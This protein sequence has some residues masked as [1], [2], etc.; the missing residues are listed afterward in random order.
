MLRTGLI[1]GLSIGLVASFIACG[2]D[3]FTEH[4]SGGSAPSGGAGGTGG[5]TGGTL[6]TGGSNTGGS[7]GG[8]GGSGGGTGGTTQS[9]FDV[10]QDGVTDC[11]GDCDD[12]DPSSFP[13]APEICGD[14]LDNDCDGDPDQ[15]AACPA[16]LG[17]YVSQVTG[18]DSNP[19]TQASP[20]QTIAQ[21][22]A[23]ALTL[24]NGQDVFV[25]EG[26]YVEKVTLVDAVSLLGGYHCDANT[27]DWARDPS[28]YV[29]LIQN[30][31]RQ[32]VL[33]DVTVSNITEISGFTIAGI[34]SSGLGGY[35]TPGTA[36]VTLAGG[37]AVVRSNIINAGDEVNCNT[38]NECSSYGVR[39]V[40]PTNDP[41]SGVLI[42]NN[43][44]TAGSSQ[45][46]GCPAVALV[47]NPAPI[48]KLV[49]NWIKGGTCNYNRAVD[50]WQSGAGTLIQNNDIFAG[51]S[52]TDTSFAMIVSGYT[53]I[54]SNRINWDHNEVGSCNNVNL[55]FWCG[56]IECEGATT[57]ITNNVVYGM[58]AARSTAIFMGD[59]EVPF[60]LITMNGN[61]LN[62][63]G[64]GQGGSPLTNTS[65]AL[66]CRTTQGLNAKVGKIR[67]NI[68]LGGL[69]QNRFGMFE[70]NQ[71]NNRTC[72]PIVYE[73]NDIF[74]PPLGSNPVDNAHRQW[75]SGAQQVLLPTFAEVN[76]QSYA[77][78][79]I[80]DDPLLDNSWHLQAGS[81]CIDAGTT[82][83]APAVDLDGDPR[84]QGA[85]V[86]IGAD[87]SN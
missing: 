50:A 4:G 30:V 35:A 12:D 49:G 54:D 36:A 55:S 81:P 5:S 77:Q 19:G 16:G 47:R 68:L 43:R 45:S 53:T 57:V 14:G 41:A 23:N 17:T 63:N 62:A 27:C 21:G 44:I 18:L 11:E 26:T 67:N 38:W 59:G 7:V 20:V 15:A 51:T 32:G 80:G 22:I 10:D 85:G 31:D 46:Q 74:F 25:A 33:A 28:L 83:D 61:T 40:G 72:E 60:G 9:C 58:P 34:D 2:G 52:P 87:E 48:A 37:T 65:A 82:A 64:T 6:N 76:A 71:T 78:A 56:G 13:G 39:I 84:P 86:D 8:M 1:A 69:G 24:A 75:T 73:N 70:M 42:E 66:S 3:D 29:S 79:N